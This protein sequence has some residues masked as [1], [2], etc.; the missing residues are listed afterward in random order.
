MSNY[1][2]ALKSATLGITVTVH[3]IEFHSKTVFINIFPESS[4]GDN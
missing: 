4:D 2:G 3:L 1:N